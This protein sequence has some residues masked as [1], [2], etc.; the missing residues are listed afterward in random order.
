MSA[1]VERLGGRGLVHW[2]PSRLGFHNAQAAR[3]RAA[4]LQAGNCRAGRL[5][6]GKFERSAGRGAKLR[7]LS[8]ILA[9]LT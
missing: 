2:R 1:E 5:D 3:R 9:V 7:H 4:S 6:L 8:T